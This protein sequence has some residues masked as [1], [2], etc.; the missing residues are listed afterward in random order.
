[1]AALR[2]S[3]GFSLNELRAALKS[4]P[5]V[6]FMIYSAGCVDYL[7][8]PHLK[9]FEADWTKKVHKR[10]VKQGRKTKTIQVTTHALHVRPTIELSVYQRRG[11]RFMLLSRVEETGGGLFDFA[12]DL[13]SATMQ[14]AEPG[15]EIAGKFAREKVAAYRDKAR[16]ITKRVE[17]LNGHVRLLRATLAS[18]IAPEEAEAVQGKID[19]ALA[20]I[21]DLDAQAE[22]LLQILEDPRGAANRLAREANPTW[23][24]LATGFPVDRGCFGRGRPFSCGA[25]RVNL[26]ARDEKGINGLSERSGPACKGVNPQS[27]PS[28]AQCEIRVRAENIGLLMIKSASGLDGWRLFAPLQYTVEAEGDEGDVSV[29]LGAAEGVD[30]GDVFEAVRYENGE[31]IVLGYARVVRAGVGGVT[32]KADPSVLVW[33][34]GEAGVGARMEERAF[35]GV[36]LAAHSH[37][38]TPLERSKA[39]LVQGLDML[40]G[41]SLDVGYDLTPFMSWRWGQAWLRTHFDLLVRP[42]A[43]VKGEGDVE[44]LDWTWMNFQAGP[45]LKIYLV[46]RLDLFASAAGGMTFVVAS[47]SDNQ[48]K[49]ESEEEAGDDSGMGSTASLRLDGGFD[50]LLD[51]AWQLRLSGGYQKNFAALTLEP[52]DDIEEG[53]SIFHGQEVG[54]LSGWG[55]KLGLNYIW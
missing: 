29:S 10:Q 14:I 48:I 17:D 5:D 32:G 2:R 47:T 15:N 21:K 4:S 33:R 18:D 20:M 23:A 49:R 8:I 12:T 31:R 16:A 42:Q 27:L 26:P 54:T 19:E 50:I 25:G 39:P 51:P 40:G 38:I 3:A 6:E 37:L 44:R 41:L 9:A 45:E 30:A 55:A 11:E 13:G 52:P 53:A 35:I 43:S 34:A 7:A 24:D 36:A 1:P 22:T 46:R 28:V